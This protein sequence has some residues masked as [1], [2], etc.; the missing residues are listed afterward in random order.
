[1]LLHSYFAMRQV[2]LCGGVLVI[3]Y[4]HDTMFVQATEHCEQYMTLINLL[5]F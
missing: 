4:F 5:L 3:I 1:M 2:P